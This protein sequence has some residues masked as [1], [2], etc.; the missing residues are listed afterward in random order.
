MDLPQLKPLSRPSKK[1]YLIYTLAVLFLFYEMA[2]QVSPSVMTH[3][4]MK[5]LQID[6]ASLGVMAA[7][8]FYSYTLMQIP[9]GLLFDRFN[10]R[11]LITSAIIICLLGA[12]FF[13]NTHTL[14]FASLGRFL[15]GIGSAFAFIG[16]LVVASRWFPRKYFAFLVGIAQLL[17]ALGAMGGELPL[18]VLVNVFGWRDVITGVAF[19]GALLAVFCALII[20]D[21][22]HYKKMQIGQQNIF[23]SIADVLLKGQTWWIGIYAFCSWGPVAVFAALWGVPYLMQR[24]HMSNTASAS[25]VAMIWIG[26]AVT[27]PILGWYSDKLGK[28]CLLLRF[29]SLI[30]LICSVLIL[31]LPNLPLL[32]AYVLLFGFG[33]ATAGQILSFALVRDINHK[34]V[35]ATAIGCNNMAVVAGGA[36]FQPL[37]GLILRWTWGGSL[38]H[39]IPVYSIDNYHYALMIVPVCFFVGLIISSIFIK[40]TYCIPKY[41]D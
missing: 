39:N 13:G 34:G 24:Y 16:V 5:D 37:A 21:P 36:F 19:I 23:K 6:A 27:S 33:A 3:Q 35:I 28:R 4:L 40:E 1:S 8:Y 30:G 31:Y 41:Q 11:I 10:P 18:A 26:L 32:A 29:C 9:A 38:L 7:F 17:A 14:A 20:H 12:L 2:L 15:M 22:P 25:A